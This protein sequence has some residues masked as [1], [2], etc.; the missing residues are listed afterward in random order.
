M[1]LRLVP[2]Q[3]TEADLT[4]IEIHVDPKTGGPWSMDETGEPKG[5]GSEIVKIWVG[6]LPADAMNRINDEVYSF[7]KDG[8]SVLKT[9]QSIERKL[10]AA[11]KKWEGIVNEKGD[12]V[13]VSL[14][15][16]RHLPYWVQRFL[17]DKVN[18]LN[19]L[20]EEEEQD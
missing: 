10:V 1:P 20:N 15:A 17:L 4:L 2:D 19:F 5:E 7:K 18:E 12:P 16:I 14:E 3:F 13:K 9:G 6:M 11:I 8:S